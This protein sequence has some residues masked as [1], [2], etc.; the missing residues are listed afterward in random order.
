M[1]ATQ[2]NF[3]Q[4]LTLNFFKP[5]SEL[6]NVRHLHF[7]NVFSKIATVFQRITFG[8]GLGR[9]LSPS[10]IVVGQ[11]KEDAFGTSVP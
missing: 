10:P 3:E 5:N 2:G 4:A 1:A 9:K 7:L 6:C 8:T 11:K